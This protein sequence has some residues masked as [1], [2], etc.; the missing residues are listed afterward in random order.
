MLGDCPEQN[1]FKNRQVSQ[2]VASA[3][4]A[5]RDIGQH[6]PFDLRDKLLSSGSDRQLENTCVCVF[7]LFFF[8]CERIKKV[9]PFIALPCPAIII[10]S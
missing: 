7:F 5:Q 1:S 8:Y 10:Y 4:H 3:L 6:L 9:M 2:Q